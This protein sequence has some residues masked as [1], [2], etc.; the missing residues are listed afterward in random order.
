MTRRKRVVYVGGPMCGTVERWKHGEIAE[1]ISCDFGHREYLY[2]FALW[3]DQ[4]N[5]LRAGHRYVFLGHK[6]KL[7]EG[8]REID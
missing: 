2:R 8:M 7:P 5:G 6:A 1:Y 4:K 3:L